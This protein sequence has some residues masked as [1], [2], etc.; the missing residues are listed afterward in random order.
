MQ[1]RKLKVMMD[2]D[3]GYVPAYAHEG[4][5]GLDLRAVEDVT[6]PAGQSAMVRTGLHVE[7]PAG[8]VGLQFPRSGLG[9]KGIP[10]GFRFFRAG[11]AVPEGGRV[12]LADCPDLGPILMVL[13]LFCEGETVIRNAGRLR[14]KESDRIA[15]M[16]AELRKFGGQIESTENTVTVRGSRLHTPVEDLDGHNDHRVVMSLTVLAAA[17]G[18]PATITGA[19]AV[20]KSWPDFFDAMRRLGVEVDEYA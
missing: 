17:A 4:D 10:G 19:E 20:A 14:L 5:A 15:A 6:I 7:I 16:E 2:S 3:A 8:C 12:D 11:D 13:G 9:S 18:L 1:Y